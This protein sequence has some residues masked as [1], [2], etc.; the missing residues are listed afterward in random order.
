MLPRCLAAVLLFGSIVHADTINVGL[1]SF[2]PFIAGSADTP[3]VNIFSIFNF[4]DD[5]ISGGFALPPDFPVITPLTFTFGSLIVMG[6]GGTQIIPLG[7]IGPGPLSP[8]ASL[9]FPDTTLFSSVIFAATLNQSSFLLSDG[10]TFVAGSSAILAELLP[11][12]GNSLEPGGDFAL[13][14]VSSVP[15][16]RYLT[17]TAAALLALLYAKRKHLSHEAKRSKTDAA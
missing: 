14:S 7:D 11:A 16:P 8:L 13:I 15:E 3:G 17:V 6:P 4:T 2:D 10:S 9:Q 12:S 5:P 1:I